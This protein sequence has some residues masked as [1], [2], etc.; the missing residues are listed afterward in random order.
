VKVRQ[1]NSTLSVDTDKPLRRKTEL[2]R[3]SLADNR[4][5]RRPSL[6]KRAAISP[7]SSAQREAVRGKV[8]LGCGREASDWLAI[9]PAHLWPRGR[10][11][12]DSRF[13]VVPLC[14]DGSGQGCHRLFDEGKFDL[15]SVVVA[16]WGRWRHH[17]QHA[18]RHATPV[19]L[20]ERLAGERVVW[21][22]SRLAREA[23]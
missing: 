7:A 15:W 8:C 2:Q 19:E 20:L 10:G 6:R 17:F 13:C 4:G 3:S 5:R 22:G 9:D 23:G 1:H 16:D 11:G 18:L 21:S 12:C 14:R